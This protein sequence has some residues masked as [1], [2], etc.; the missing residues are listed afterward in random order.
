MSDSTLRPIGVV[1]PNLI[2]SL[3]WSAD[4]V[5]IR[6]LNAIAADDERLSRF[7]AVSGLDPATLRQAAHLPGFLLGVLDYVAADEATLLEVAEAVGAPPSV[8]V[9]AREALAPKPEPE[10]VELAPAT[11]KPL[12]LFC[13]G[14]GEKRRVA[15]AAAPAVPARVV[16]IETPACQACG[17]GSEVP[18]TW[19]DARGN[20][21]AAE[22]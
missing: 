7:L 20:E 4:E 13:K 12:T 21:V 15:R 19:L 11:R 10:A 16:M 9:R 22:G 3:L 5:A 2:A 17:D 14:C 18:T 6:A 1:N 8:L